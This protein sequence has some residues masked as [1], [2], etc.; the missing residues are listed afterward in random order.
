MSTITCA[1]STLNDEFRYS[2]ED[3]KA[4]ILD[5]AR[6]KYPSYWVDID[7]LYQSFKPHDSATDKPRGYILLSRPNTED[8]QKSCLRLNLNKQSY[9]S[10]RRTLKK[11]LAHATSLQET[12]HTF[13][14]VISATRNIPLDRRTLSQSDEKK[15]ED[16]QK[17]EEALNATYSRL[18]ADLKVWQ[19][20]SRLS[21]SSAFEGLCNV[22]FIAMLLADLLPVNQA[23]QDEAN[24]YLASFEEA[25][26]ELPTL[27]TE[28]DIIKGL[29]NNLNCCCAGEKCC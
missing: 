2:P 26:K 11:E 10:L 18:E 24:R 17:A 21:I 19:D 8:Q 9:S 20:R 28:M 16:V 15:P 14:T 3:R 23:L 6:F 27:D 5:V 29:L 25:R 4:L 7:L 13:H 1:V 12:F 22:L